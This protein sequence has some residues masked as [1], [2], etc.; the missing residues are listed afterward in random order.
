MESLR[1]LVGAVAGLLAAGALIVSL[2]AQGGRFS[3]R[4]DVLTHFA[5]LYLAPAI[6]AL[7]LAL[8]AARPMRG[9]VALTALAAVAA[10]AVLVAPEFLSVGRDPRAAAD[11][12]D[13]LKVIQ[14]NAWGRNEQAEA[15]VAWLVAQK[16][17]IIV[18]QE[19]GR[20]RD[21]LIARGFIT[22]CKGCSA[23]V[24]ARR[25]PVRTFAE[26]RA[27]GHSAYLVSSTYADA[28]GEFTVVAIHRFWPTRFARDRAQT[29][30]LRELIAEAPKERLILAGDFNS[31][32]W[33]FARRAEDRDFGMI[34]RTRALF[35]WPAARISHNRLPAPFPYLP[36]DHVYA[37]PGWATVSVE[38]GP[39]LGSDHYPVVVTLAPADASAVHPR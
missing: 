27:D 5:P 16:P 21:L 13:Q 14:F 8:F 39:K 11:A 30:Q 26:G 35:S 34:R 36:I 33:S 7:A 4:L 38:R 23:G 28:R 29:A 6:L 32:P 37:G 18:M 20:L 10:V 2:A 12:P 31:T 3:P 22:S 24:M 15:A 17:D 25:A 19:G 9:P 1:F